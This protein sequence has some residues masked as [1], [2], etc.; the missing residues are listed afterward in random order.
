MNGGE[1]SAQASGEA[2][3]AVLGRPA[4]ASTDRYYDALLRY[5]RSVYGRSVPARQ[6]DEAQAAD[7][8]AGSASPQ[9]ASYAARRGGFPRRLWRRLSSR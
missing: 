3:Q 7:G 2:R 5:A 6:D 9:P 1:K 8:R 4:T